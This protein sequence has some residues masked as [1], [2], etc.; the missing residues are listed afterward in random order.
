MAFYLGEATSITF[1]TLPF[2]FLRLAI[3]FL[4]GLVFCIYWVLVY[5]VANA[6]ASLHQ[7]ATVAIWVIAFLIPFPIIRFLREYVFYVLKAG[8]V[9]VMAELAIT[10]KLP[11]GMGQIAW[12]KKQVMARFKQTSVLFLVDRLVAGVIAAINGVMWRVGHVFSGIPGVGG[13]VKLANLVLRFSLTYVDEAI[14]ARNFVNEK[15]TVW[16]SA[17]TGLVLYAQIWRQVLATA[18]MLG[19]FAM[20]S[21]TVLAFV[22]LIPFLGFA[23]AIPGSTPFFVIGA[24]VFAAVIKLALF[25]P[26]TLANMMLVYLN[27]TKNLA[28]DPVWEEKLETFSK[29]FKEIKKRALG[30]S[31]SCPL[32]QKVEGKNKI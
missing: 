12:G 28:V 13:L 1:K 32:P 25:D 4:F 21:Y 7:Y 14:L 23:Q 2:I 26:W 29:K 31:G 3:Y 9:A 15:E 20:L 18:L 17:K 30:E 24:L 16:Q 19:I 5:F 8:H 27:E 22:F 11:E 6:F 10:G